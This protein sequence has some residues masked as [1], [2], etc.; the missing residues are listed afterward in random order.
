[1]ALERESD[2]TGLTPCQGE[3]IR[4]HGIN[5]SGGGVTNVGVMPVV[6]LKMA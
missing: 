4:R 5:S 2:V 3:G 1:M 6:A